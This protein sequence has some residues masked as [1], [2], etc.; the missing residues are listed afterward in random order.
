MAVN[1]DGDEVQQTEIEK[2]DRI[3]LF[4]TDSENFIDVFVDGKED[5]AF[6]IFRITIGED[7]NGRYCIPGN[8][9]FESNLLVDLFDGLSFPG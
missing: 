7:E 3:I 6:G 5:V 4:R 1:D 2:G 8:Y 9:G